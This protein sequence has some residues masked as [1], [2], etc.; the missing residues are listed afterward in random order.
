MCLSGGR[1]IRTWAPKKPV[2]V[3]Q[4]TTL[5][6]PYVNHI[7][8]VSGFSWS[9]EHGANISAAS[10]GAWDAWVAVNPKAARFRNKGWPFYDLL[11]PL[12]PSKAKGG[13]VF[14]AGARA[15]APP[16]ERSSSPE[17]DL[18]EL[19][20][21]S[22]EKDD[23]ARDGT[24][25]DDADAVD[26]GTTADGL[27]ADIEDD[28]ETGSSSPAPSVRAQKRPAAQSTVY[29]KKPRVTAG[30]QGLVDL[31]RTAAEFNEIMGSI[32]DI[33]AS[34][35]NSPAASTASSASTLSNP[36][37]SNPGPSIPLFLYCS[38]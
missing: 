1:G 8:G 34:S 33:F 20:Q 14:R 28:N 23:G 31:D 30:A 25:S 27:G 7:K 17:W 26:V 12:M 16:A 36:V 3:T 10:Q 9:D 13:N 29:R 19:E 32:R 38:N 22:R 37:P 24:S 5:P 21:E 2:Y 35:S 4:T 18:R 6:C 11:A 15:P